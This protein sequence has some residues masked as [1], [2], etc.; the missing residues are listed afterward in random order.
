MINIQIYIR[1]EYFEKPINDIDLYIIFD[2]DDPTNLIRGNMYV[3]N[4]L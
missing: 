4:I 1:I 2:N 3:D